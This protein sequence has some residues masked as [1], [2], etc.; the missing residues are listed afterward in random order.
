MISVQMT[1]FV[2]TLEK[3][4]NM[5]KLAKATNSFKSLVRATQEQT[6]PYEWFLHET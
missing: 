4:L 6:G 3:V 5:R 1:A 2:R